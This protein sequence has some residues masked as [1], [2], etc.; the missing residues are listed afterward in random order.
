MEQE[1]HMDTRSAPESR[2]ATAQAR[3]ALKSGALGSALEW[4]DFAIYGALSAT[5][6]PQLFF[7]DMTAANAALASFATF[8]VGFVARPLGG[9]IFGYLGDKVGRRTILMV[10]FV[11]MGLASLVIGLLPTAADIGFLAPLTLV[12][13]RF[14][15]GFALGGEV[16]GAQLMTMEHAPKDRRAFYAAMMSM[17]SPI[18]QVLANL[19]LAVLSFA[20]T[21]EAFLAWGWRIPFILSI[22]LIIVGIFIRYRVEETPIYREE[23][24]AV[25]GVIHPLAVLKSHGL[26]ILRLILAYAPFVITFYFVIIFGISY[27]TKTLHY[28]TSET[29]TIIMLANFVSIF[30]I[31]AGGKTADRIGRRPVFFIGGAICLVA[32]L[33]FFPVVGLGS[34]PLT[35]LITT[36][37]ISAV[38]FSNA[39]QGAMFAEA[40]PTHLRYTGSALALTGS[41]LIFSAPGPFVAT[42]LLTLGH[43]PLPI[44][45]AW[46][47]LIFVGLII[48]FLGKEGKSLEGS[49]QSFTRSA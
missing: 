46:A 19:S 48:I 47:G 44:A 5:V 6:F 29:F 30:A 33:L 26:T 34:F 25:R 32:A 8:G 11:S 36:V 15:Q 24:E 40:F 27:M 16:T 41:N 12:L 7:N 14:I 42:W 28:G 49:E 2:P 45:A 23:T 3:T 10:T 43:G 21:P 38:Q 39:A 4:F 18:S 1:I 31:W 22:G 9:L 20:L 13:M 17:G 35:A 37:A